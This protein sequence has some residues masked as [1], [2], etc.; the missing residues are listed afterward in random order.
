MGKVTGWDLWQKDNKNC[1]QCGMKMKG[2]K[3]GCCKDEYQNVKLKVDQKTVRY[4]VPDFSFCSIPDG[5]DNIDSLPLQIN[6][7]A[8]APLNKSA[9][10]SWS[11][12]LYVRNRL[13]L[14]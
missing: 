13:F 7:N 5:C 12:P 3:D 6:K 14:I 4:S 9:L 10:R 2:T 8:L 11:V 1:D